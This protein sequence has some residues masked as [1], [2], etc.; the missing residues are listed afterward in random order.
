MQKS[1][2]DC[3]VTIDAVNLD[4]SRNEICIRVL[5]V[6]DDSC[7]LEVSKQILIAMGL[8]ILIEKF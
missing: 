6:D 4:S 5:L 2:Q 7:V 1:Y 3:R 8:I